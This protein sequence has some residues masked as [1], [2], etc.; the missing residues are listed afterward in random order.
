MQAVITDLDGT[1][2]DEGGR[3]S[4]RT[5]AAM[6]SLSSRG[7]PLILA[8]AR[9]P[10]WVMAKEELVRWT[11]VAVCCGGS[12]V[13]SPKD[14]RILRRETIPRAKVESV[15]N[16]VRAVPTA[17]IATYDGDRWRGT[18]IFHELGPRRP[19]LFEIV[20]IETLERAT[21]C[22]ISIWAPSHEARAALWTTLSQI[23]TQRLRISGAGGNTI[24]LGPTGID[25][26]VGLRWA[27]ERV[28]VEPTL[29]IAFGDGPADLPMFALCGQS[30]AVANAH[31]DVLAAATIR[32]PC[33]HEDCF[34]S[35]LRDLGVLDYE[36]EQ[37]EHV[38][39][40]CSCPQV[41]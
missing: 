34:A 5:V 2:V 25:K 22:A 15:V 28:R 29:T 27:L 6:A 31:P 10:A 35:T 9:S 38:A 39:P 20:G 18:A 17:G 41:G 32:G 16:V 26:A 13:W 14:R 19:G 1:V 23:D 30:V 33:V 7:I 21:A 37:E 12:V 4:A 11:T 40:A 36:E 8:T 3:I 24:N